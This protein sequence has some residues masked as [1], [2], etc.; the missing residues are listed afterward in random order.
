MVRRW[1]D[2]VRSLPRREF[3]PAIGAIILVNALGAAPAVL[4][5]ADTGW[6]ERPWYYPPEILFPLVWTL[7]FS[8]MGLAAYLI[9]REDLGSA[10]VQLALGAFAVQFALNVVWTPAFFGLQ[11]PDIGLAIIGILWIAIIVTIVAFD[12]VR[13]R[14]AILLVPYLLWV[15]FAAVLTFDIWLAWR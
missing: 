2:T 8:L 3:L 1:L 6:I 14:A 13:R 11:R 7:L 4:F 5:G 15:S 10:S 9:W 12:R